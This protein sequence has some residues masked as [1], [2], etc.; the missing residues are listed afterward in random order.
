MLAALLPAAASAIGAGLS[1]FRGKQQ[2]K[3]QKQ[4]AQK[5]IQWKV[6]DAKAAGIHPLYALGA[7]THSYAPSTVGDAGP[8]VAQAGQD[9]SRAI[10]T[11]RTSSQKVDAY[12]KTVQALSLRKMGLENELLSAQIA[13]INQTMSPPMAGADRMLVDGQ[14]QSGLILEKPMERQARAPGRPF[15]EAG[16]VPD[17]GYSRTETGWAPT[18]SQDVKQRLEDDWPGVIAWNI[19]N[20]LGPSFQLNRQPPDVPLKPGHI[21]MFNPYK[22]EYQQ[23]PKN[24]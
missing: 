10:D 23:W 8:L 24:F 1:Y 17:L 9:I 15:Q 22:M 21:W 19:R 14:T 4:F 2:D 3:L 16:A 18:F 5:G 7:Q 6:N 13:K 20:R 11:T 12:T